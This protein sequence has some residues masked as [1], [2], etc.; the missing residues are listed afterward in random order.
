MASGSRKIGIGIQ[1]MVKLQ[2][3]KG[4]GGSLQP[5]RLPCLIRP[6]LDDGGVDGE[7]QRRLPIL[8]ILP[9]FTMV[10]VLLGA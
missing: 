8:I 4:Y 5:P 9:M 10:S 6:F 3:F 1:K 2:F 7:F